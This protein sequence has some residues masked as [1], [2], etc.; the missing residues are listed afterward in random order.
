MAN[1]TERLIELRQE[2]TLS[3]KALAMVIN[4]SES[5]INKWELGKR[6]PTADS[7]IALAKFF[8]VTTDYLVGLSDYK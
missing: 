6:S 3:Q 8:G 7:I 4:A 1:F 2:K 5:A